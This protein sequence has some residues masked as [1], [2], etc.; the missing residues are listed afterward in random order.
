VEQCF[1]PITRVF[2]NAGPGGGLYAIANLASAPP[3]IARSLSRYGSIK[4]GGITLPVPQHQSKLARAA[5]LGFIRAGSE[6]GLVSKLEFVDSPN[7]HG[8]TSKENE[9]VSFTKASWDSGERQTPVTDLNSTLIKGVSPAIPHVMSIGGDQ[10]AASESR[11]VEMLPK[12]AGSGSVDQPAPSNPA[13]TV[14]GMMTRA[15]KLLSTL[16]SRYSSDEDIVLAAGLIERAFGQ[17]DGLL[18]DGQVLDRLT[19]PGDPNRVTTAGEAIDTTAALNRM[20][21]YGLTT[22]EIE[23]AKRTG[24]NLFVEGVVEA[25]QSGESRRSFTFR[26][27]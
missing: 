3:A 27:P 11:L 21:K 12:G 20:A 17:L 16:A 2:E 18:D 25:R 14:R 7:G 26:M 4:D 24:R 23:M 15:T 22:E 8:S 13:G 19:A 10:K 6:R 9:G 1:L 5:V